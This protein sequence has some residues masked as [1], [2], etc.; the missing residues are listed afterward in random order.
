MSISYFIPAP[1][2]LFAKGAFCVRA[3]SS[4]YLQML[5]LFK[6]R[7]LVLFFPLPCHKA[8]GIPTKK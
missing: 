8:R 7:F 5:A 2:I 3:C 1:S 4:P 6:G